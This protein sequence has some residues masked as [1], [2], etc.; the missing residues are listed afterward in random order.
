VRRGRGQPPHHESRPAPDSSSPVLVCFFFF[1]FCFH[2]FR[3]A[4]DSSSPVV[5]S[6]FRF[7]PSIVFCFQ[8]GDDRVLLLGDRRWLWFSLA[9]RRR[10]WWW[11]SFAPAC[12]Y[13]ACW[14]SGA[15][16]VGVVVTDFAA[17]DL[18]LVSACVFM[19]GLCCHVAFCCWCG[20][21]LGSFWCKGCGF[22][23]LSPRRNVVWRAS[24]IVRRKKVAV[25]DMCF[26]GVDFLV[27]MWLLWAEVM[28][29]GC[30]G[31][32]MLT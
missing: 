32:E 27:L 3:P 7:S 14:C 21:L 19:R 6:F 28:R 13:V 12:S 16:G 8:K 1:L 22:Y 30:G 4:P 29:W 18:V 24:G 11:F 25:L 17:A 15:V 31:V 20:F 9:A 26:S 2:D 23:F 5:G 10:R